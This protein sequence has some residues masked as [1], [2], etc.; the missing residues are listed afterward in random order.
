MALPRL[1]DANRRWWVLDARAF[2]LG[3]A[4]FVLAS[5]A[6]G[7]AQGEASIIAARAVQGLGAAL[8]TPATGALASAFGVAAAV[9]AL[10]AIVAVVLLRHRPATD[11]GL[12][13]EACG[14]PIASTAAAP[15]AE[16][17]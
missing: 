14:E 3:A 16:P 15:V 9:L 2:K 13:A 1:T 5:A 8:L 6:C 12:P 7:L 10:A 17:V 11:A 4:L